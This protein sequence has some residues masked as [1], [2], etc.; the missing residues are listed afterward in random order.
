VRFTDTQ[1][2]TLLGGVCHSPTLAAHSYH[3]EYRNARSQALIRL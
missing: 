2:G 1:A 3:A